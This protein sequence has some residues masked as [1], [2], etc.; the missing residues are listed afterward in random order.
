LAF[1]WRGTAQFFSQAS[2]KR[3]HGIRAQA[4]AAT[5][6][7]P[8]CRLRQETEPNIVGATIYDTHIE[9]E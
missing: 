2:R 6:A 8:G 4:R 1:G 9:A 7:R 3:R 5:A